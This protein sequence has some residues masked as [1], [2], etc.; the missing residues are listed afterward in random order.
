MIPSCNKTSGSQCSFGCHTEA[1]VGL[2]H[3]LVHS[4]SS[5]VGP[6]ASVESLR[7][8]GAGIICLQHSG[9]Q[10][11]WQLPHSFTSFFFLPSV[12]IMCVL[13]KSPLVAYGRRLVLVP[14]LP[15]QFLSFLST[16]IIETDSSLFHS[17]CLMF[18]L[19]TI[20]CYHTNIL[21][22]LNVLAMAVL[23]ETHCMYVMSLWSF[24]IS[25]K[26]FQQPINP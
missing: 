16:Q 12:S 5:S 2:V 8:S 11:S 10:S 24:S 15:W 1:L 3:G 14:S 20:C 21:E 13:W 6:P 9:D 26:N 19:H 22:V 7:I 18:H 17:N 25:L 23:H 4:A